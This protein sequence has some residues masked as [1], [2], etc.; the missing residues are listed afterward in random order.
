MD[1]S[2]G[3]STVR[4]RAE[5]GGAGQ[6]RTRHGMAGS[7][8]KYAYIFLFNIVQLMDLRYSGLVVRTLCS[9]P[10]CYEDG[11]FLSVFNELGTC[12]A[13]NFSRHPK[14]RTPESRL[15]ERSRTT[16]AH[17]LK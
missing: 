8:P 4:G 13:T 7:D 2:T 1:S 9:R 3:L 15:I 11:P 14:L 5:W 17:R 12:T 16:L 6:G 10:N